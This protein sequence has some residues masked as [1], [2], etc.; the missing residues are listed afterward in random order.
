MTAQTRSEVPSPLPDDAR[1]LAG[2][3]AQVTWFN[4]L[5]LLVAAG[6]VWLTALASHVLDIVN[7]P[8]PLYALAA[9]TVAVDVYYMV[10][11]RA[12]ER[13][14][15]HAVRRHVYLQILVDLLILTALLHYTGGITNPFALCYLFHA[16]IAALVLS[17][18]AAVAVA[19]SSVVLLVLLGAA[20]RLG[21]LAHRSL[22][23]GLIDLHAVEPLG[24]WLLVLAYAVTL[25]FSIYFVSTVLGRLKRNESE[26]M[27][28]GR[29]FAVSEKLAS[30]GTLAAGVSHEI[31][32]PIGVIANKVQILRYRIADRDAP[33]ALFAELDVIEKHTRRVAQITAGL[34]AF[35][36]ETAFERK[37]VDLAVLC[38]EAADLVRVPFKAADVDLACREIAPNEAV[39]EGS[40]NHLLQVLINIL[41]NAKDASPRGSGV[42]MWIDRGPGEVVVSIRD[43]GAGIRP[44]HLAKVFDPF[45]TTKEVDKGTGLGLAISHGIVERHRGRLEVESEFGRGA[46]FRIVL[47]MRMAI[48]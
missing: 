40:A 17:V 11:F 39:V 38:R 30:V 3:L 21:W 35:A 32:N 9:L 16:F 48:S 28:L 18:G 20:E 2:L 27:R 19:A 25:A 13:A 44:E 23:L 6:V 37:A 31:N 33:E 4:R 42:E 24:F 47:P 8:L 26:L 7:D 43:H 34:L 15:V 46:T 41:L 5:R 1:E 45:F 36:R 10:R 22:H 29:H 12:L 14:S